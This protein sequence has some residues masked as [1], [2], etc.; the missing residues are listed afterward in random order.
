LLEAKDLVYEDVERRVGYQS[1]EETRCWAVVTG[2]ADEEEEEEGQALIEE[3]RVEE[4]QVVLPLLI[5]D[6]WRC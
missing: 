3:S 5:F 1:E 6:R 4:E 2:I